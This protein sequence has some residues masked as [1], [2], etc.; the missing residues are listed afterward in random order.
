MIVD[1]R[2]TEFF[3]FDDHTHMGPRANPSLAFPAAFDLGEMLLDMDRSGVDMAVAFPRSNPVTDYRVENELILSFQEKYPDRIAAFARIQPFFKE[4]APSD[5]REYA[6][7]GVRG[8]QVPPDHR[9]WQQRGQQS[10]THVPGD[11]RSLPPSHDRP[12]P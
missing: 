7:R 11:G 12:D 6:E 3:V 4:T 5:I 1:E 2:G 10:R 9:W 8:L